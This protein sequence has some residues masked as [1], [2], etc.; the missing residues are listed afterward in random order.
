MICDTQKNATGLGPA[1]APLGEILN[2]E[3]YAFGRP[4]PRPCARTGADRERTVTA[5]LHQPYLQPSFR[6]VEVEGHGS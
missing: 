1:G 6:V 2:D 4:R 3:S 5:M